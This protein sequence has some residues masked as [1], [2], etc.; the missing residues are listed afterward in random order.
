MD[1]ELKRCVWEVTVGCNMH[2][3]HCGSSCTTAKPDELT[4]EEALLVAEQLVGMKVEYVSLTG[5][6]PLLRKDW[7]QIARRLAD[8]GVC[9]G[10][11]TNGFLI[12]EKTVAQMEESGLAIVS[13]SMDGPR[14]Q[15]NAMRGVDCYDQSVQ[16]YKL[17]RN[18]SLQRGANTTV[19]KENIDTLPQLAE[20]LRSM[21][22][23]HWQIQLGIPVGRLKEHQESVL[24]PE[25]VDRIIDFAYEE[26]EKGGLH[27]V[28][29]E[30]IGYYSRKGVDRHTDAVWRGCNAGIRSLGILQNGDVVAC[31]SIRDPRF[32]VGNLR[33]RTL[34]EIWEDE[35]SFAW[36]RQMKVEDLQGKCGTCRYAAACLGGCTNSKL[37]FGGNIYAENQYCIYYQKE[38]KNQCK[39]LVEWRKKY[40]KRS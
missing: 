38:L 7:N 9:T 17:L 39:R 3:R 15:H 8:G 25:A 19:V 32:T 1:Y 23:E 31:T 21:G 14:E 36:R 22:V 27:V 29:A 24:G 10:L 34:R 11:I 33:T 5:G 4:T 35:E 20:E 28:V 16:A 18:S 30:S 13:L 40:G 26:N 6:E 12:T 2:C 37:A